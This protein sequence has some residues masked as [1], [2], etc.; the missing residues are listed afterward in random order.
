VTPGTPADG[1]LL[2]A[3]VHDGD[4]KMPPKGKLAQAQIDVLT[5]WVKMGA[6]WPAGSVVTKPDGP[7]PVDDKARNFWSFRPVVR[8]AVP[9]V[10]SGRKEW[11]RNPV[12]AF[13]LATLTAKGLSPAP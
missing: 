4:L 5:T 7:P 11:V 12:D 10:E 2:K 8:P 6:P 3:I 9:P 13:V 1:L